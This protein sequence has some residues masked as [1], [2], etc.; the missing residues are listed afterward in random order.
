MIDPT[1]AATPQWVVVKLVPKADGK[2]DK[3]GAAKKATAKPN[4]RKTSNR[5]KP[6]APALS[7]SDGLAPLKRKMPAAE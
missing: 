4:K 6:D 1:L 5:P 2:T 7:S 3:K